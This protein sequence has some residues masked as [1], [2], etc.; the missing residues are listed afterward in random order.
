MRCLTLADALK[1]NGANC[2]FICREHPGNLLSY[3]ESK[4]HNVYAISAHAEGAESPSTR[5]LT[6]SGIAKLAHAHWLGVSQQQ[7]ANACAAFL[8]QLQVDWLIVD[9][10][11][12]DACWEGMLHQYCRKLMVID[13]LADR[14]H[15][16]DFLVDQTFGRNVDDYVQR[17]PAGCKVLCGAQYSML[18]PEFA[19][20]RQ[21]S[22][23]R[24]KTR[25][26][27]RLLVTMG[28]VDS[29]NATVKV[30]EALRC[31]DLPP[32]CSITVVMGNNAP[33]L[34]EVQ[35]QAELMPWP[36]HIRVGVSDMAHLM[37]DSDLAI[38]AAGSTS[39][40]R[41][42]LGLPTVMVVLADNQRQ[43]A[44]WLEAGGAAVT[45]DLQQIDQFLPT[46]MDQL[47]SRLTHRLLMSQVAA[48][49][50][51]GSG[52]AAIIQQLES[53]K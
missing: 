32:S 37:A 17:V 13:D 40:E 51:D 39:W 36:T 46:L 4:G 10:Y 50:T 18:R 53:V 21:Y 8:S 9:H 27:R 47:I 33:W 29:N 48:E 19:A 14:N 34:S 25:D 3:I 42:C 20:L 7:D 16:C 45:V 15:N 6:P 52:V 2:H 38:G 1:A 44:H 24:R 28:G 23:N 31:C 11:A 43:L 22:L 5:V 41:C 12:L 26:V 35:L 30:L 49:I